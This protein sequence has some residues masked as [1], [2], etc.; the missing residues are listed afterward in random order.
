MQPHAVHVSDFS[1]LTEPTS[2][3]TVASSDLSPDPSAGFDSGGVM[4][5]G[6]RGPFL[7][8]SSC[9]DFE[10]VDEGRKISSQLWVQYG[11]LSVS[12]S[13]LCRGNCSRLT[14]T[15]Q[16]SAG[17]NNALKFQASNATSCSACL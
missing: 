3:N 17:S 5:K 2:R 1:I 4:N 7:L 15:F 8:N 6:F 10:K 14:W 12:R 9:H 13:R 16:S 11:S